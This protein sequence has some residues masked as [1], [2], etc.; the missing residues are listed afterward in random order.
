[1]ELIYIISMGL[2]L[3]LVCIPIIAFIS[4]VIESVNM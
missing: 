4:R 2:S 1:M 3:G